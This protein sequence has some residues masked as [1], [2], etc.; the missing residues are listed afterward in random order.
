LEAQFSQ[1]HFNKIGIKK[2]KTRLVSELEARRYGDPL[3]YKTFSECIKETLKKHRQAQDD[4]AY[5]AQIK[6]LAEDFREGFVGNTYPS[7]IDDDSDANQ[8]KRVG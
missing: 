7:C 3:L 5:L 8:A 1:Q 4:N 6:K 2:I